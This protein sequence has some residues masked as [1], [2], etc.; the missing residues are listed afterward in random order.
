MKP[1]KN[2]SNM[3]KLSK[4]INRRPTF[5]QT[6]YTTY[7]VH[8]LTVS[9]RVELVYVNSVYWKQTFSWYQ[10]VVSRSR[11]SD[12]VSEMAS[13]TTSVMI[14]KQQLA[15]WFCKMIAVQTLT[16]FRIKSLK[17]ELTIKDNIASISNHFFLQDSSSSPTFNNQCFVKNEPHTVHLNSESTNVY[18]LYQHVSI[19]L[20]LPQ[21]MLSIFICRCLNHLIKRTQLPI[22]I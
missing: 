19:G 21:L 18:L 1:L 4:S 20:K 12:Q 7:K 22:N 14:L 9:S 10:P 8:Q 6:T 15:S 5:K 17:S 16:F 2:I 11:D 13:W 3:G